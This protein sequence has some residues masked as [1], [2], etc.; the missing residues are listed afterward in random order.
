MLV[1]FLTIKK[2]VTAQMFIVYV[3]IMAFS[4]LRMQN[5]YIVDLLIRNEGVIEI[6]IKNCMYSLI[7]QQ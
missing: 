7:S 3:D 4:Q 5:A 2:F 1:Y 6:I